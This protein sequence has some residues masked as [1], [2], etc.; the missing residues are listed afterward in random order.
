MTGGIAEELF[1]ETIYFEFAPKLKMHNVIAKELYRVNSVGLKDSILQAGNIA[2]AV[3]DG[4]H[5][6]IIEPVQKITKKTSGKRK[7]G[8][9]TV[10]KRKED[11]EEKKEEEDVAQPKRM[12]RA[13]M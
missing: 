9:I 3:E 12:R 13:K 1:D 8:G 11:E 7:A 2:I 5:S 4:P 6:L 10:E